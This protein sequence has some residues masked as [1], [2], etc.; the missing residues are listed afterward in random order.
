MNELFRI[1][2]FFMRE[3]KISGI[4]KYLVQTEQRKLI[5]RY[6][7]FLLE[8]RRYFKQWFGEVSE[9]LNT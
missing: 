8:V 2:D 7:T 1:S 9:K 3:Y 4:K 6:K 5:I